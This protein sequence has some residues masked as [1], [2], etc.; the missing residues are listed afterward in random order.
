MTYLSFT[1]N[2]L[3][4]SVTQQAQNAY[5]V[6]DLSSVPNLTELYNLTLL[7]QILQQHEDQ[8]ITS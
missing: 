5:L 6:G 8:T 2:P 1:V 3:E 4:T 7:N